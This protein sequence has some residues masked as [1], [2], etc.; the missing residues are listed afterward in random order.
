MPKTRGKNA[1]QRHDPLAKQY[2]DSEVIPE[3]GGKKSKK[4]QIVADETVC[5]RTSMEIY[6]YHALRRTRRIFPT[7]YPSQ[8][9]KRFWSKLGSSKKSLEATFLRTLYPLQSAS[10]FLIAAIVVAVL[11]LQ[12]RLNRFQYGSDDDSVFSEDEEHYL[13]GAVSRATRAGAGDVRSLY[14][15]IGIVP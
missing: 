11:M 8:C 10:W 3:D 7:T 9:H 12:G 15:G 6:A 5:S 14:L 2:R 4:K 13:D 1:P